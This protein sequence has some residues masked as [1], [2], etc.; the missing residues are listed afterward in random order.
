MKI[1]GILTNK[2]DFVATINST[3]TISE[4][5]NVLAE[6]NIGAVPVVDD[7][8]II[9]MASERDV[10]RAIND[11][12]PSVLDHPV[13]ELMSVRIS[14]CA[15]SATVDELMS[16][17][18]QRRVRHVPVVDE[19]DTLLGIVS[20]GDVVKARLEELEEERAQLMNYISN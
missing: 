2:G 9:G 5:L 10:V 3:A 20:I 14:V 4:L 7:D 6:Y 12:G 8:G 17:M 19:D 1:S 11:R 16:V 18:T 15:P 13:S